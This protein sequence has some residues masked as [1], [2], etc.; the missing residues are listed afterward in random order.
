[1]VLTV[2]IK[3]MATLRGAGIT[4]SD[5]YFDSSITASGK[6][7]QHALEARCELGAR[8]FTFAIFGD[9]DEAANHRL[10]SI[11]IRQL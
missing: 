9:F 8:G 3:L 6:A 1:M 11:A 7:V 2:L 10:S 4:A 5:G